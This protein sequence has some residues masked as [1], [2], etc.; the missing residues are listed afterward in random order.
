MTNLA[1]RSA[2]SLAPSLAD[3]RRGG[4]GRGGGD[5]GADGALIVGDSVRGSLRHLVLDRLG[6]SMRC[7]CSIGFFA[8]ELATELAA[9]PDVR[10]MKAKVAPAILFPAAS[11]QSSE[12][13]REATGGGRAGR[14]QREAFWEFEERDSG[15]RRR[16]ARARSSS[17]R[18]WP[19][20][21]APRS[22]T[23]WSCGSARPTRFRPT[24]R[25]AAGATARPA[26]RS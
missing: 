9:Q 22:A 11:V 12:A 14:G 20:S 8:Q 15:G 2:S 26:W 18:R 23:R 13:E 10:A 1:S 25:W 17:T 21:W 5:G 3:S 16:R 6:G 24:A 4:A 19:R 7:W